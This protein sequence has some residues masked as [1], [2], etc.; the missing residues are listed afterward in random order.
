[1]RISP[2]QLLVDKTVSRRYAFVFGKIC[3][4]CNHLVKMERMFYIK[5]KGE[6]FCTH[7]HDSKES[8]Y[9]DYFPEQVTAE[10]IIRRQE[11]K[12]VRLALVNLSSEVAELP[13]GEVS[14][15]IHSIIAKHMIEVQHDR[16]NSRGTRR[17]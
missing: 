4:T 12:R 17:T 7:C 3:S 15:M 1:M 11:K 9:D 14:P 5:S 10:D 13:D 6:Y 8:V 16:Q 2:K